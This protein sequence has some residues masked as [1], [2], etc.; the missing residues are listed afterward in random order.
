MNN[1]VQISRPRSALLLL[2]IMISPLASAALVLDPS[3]GGGAA[4]ELDRCAACHPLRFIHLGDPGVYAIVGQEGYATCYSCHG[5]NGGEEKPPVCVDCHNSG[6]LPGAPALDGTHSHNFNDTESGLGDDACVACHAASDMD[7]RFTP[8]IDLTK[9]PDANGKLTPSHSIT[10]FC[11]R[12]HNRGHQVP[13]YEIKAESRYD[14]LV[15]ME[16]NYRFIDYHGLRHGSGKRFY[17]GLRKGYRY[18]AWVECTDCHAMHGTNNPSLLIDRSGKGVAR[19]EAQFRDK[20]WPVDISEGNYAQLCVLCHQMKSPVDAAGNDT[21][22]GL[23]GIHRVT[24]DC[25]P[26][27][28]HGQAIQAG[29]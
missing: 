4:W 2:L 28:S 21:G 27:H 9:L 18:A 16:D 25:R 10:E 8:E 23:A 12:C 3:H 1:I 26:C 24:G 19:L 17:Y 29:L 14:P 20:D 7:G 13:G 11:L 22:N 5:T 6:A 15:A